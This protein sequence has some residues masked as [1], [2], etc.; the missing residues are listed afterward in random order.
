MFFGNKNKILKVVIW[1]IVIAF[2]GGG[3]GIGGSSLIMACKEKGQQDALHREALEKDE[4][5]LRIPD[6]IRN[7]E[8][9][10]IGEDKI[11]AGKFFDYFRKLNPEIK[12]RYTTVE[13]R[14]QVLDYIIEREIINNFAISSKVEVSEEDRIKVLYRLMGDQLKN[15][16]QTQVKDMI[17]KGYFDAAELNYAVTENKV[18]KMV[19]V[20]PEDRS[21]ENLRKYYEQHK[22]RYMKDNEYLV[23]HIMIKKDTPEL[24]KAVKNNIKEGTLERYYENNKRKYTGQAAVRLKG[25]FINPENFQVNSVEE[26]EIKEYF[27]KNS[28]KYIVE[29]EVKASHIL[30]KNEQKAKEILD[31]VKKGESFEELAEEY[32]EDPGSAKLKG[33]LGWFKRNT[34]VKEFDSKVFSMKPGEVSNLVATNFGYHIIKLYEKKDRREKTLEEVRNEIVNEI[35]KDLK[36]EKAQEVIDEIAY[37]INSGE[38]FE[39]YIDK[40]HGATA[41]FEG[42]LDWVTK[43]EQTSNLH[44]DRLEGE[45]FR[46]KRL[47]PEVENVIFNLRLG[48]V[49]EVVKSSTGFHLFRLVDRRQ[50]E[51][52]PYAEVKNQVEKDFMVWQKNILANNKAREALNKINS[53]HEFAAV[54]K[55]YSDGNTSEKGG[56]LPWFPMGVLPEERKDLQ[57]ALDG[58]IASFT[59]FF[60][61]NQFQAGVSVANEIENAVKRLQKGE[62]SQVVETSDAYHI[63]K[64]EDIRDGE[65]PTFEEIYAQLVEDVSVEITEEDLLDYYN[66]NIERYTEPEQVKVAHILVSEIAKAAMVYDMV[67][68]DGDFSKIAKENSEDYTKD[69]GGEIGYI[70]RGNMP[71]KFEE[72]AFSLEINEVSEPV[73]TTY[74]FHII[75]VLDKKPSVVATFEDKKEEIRDELFSPH[76]DRL[77]QQWLTEQKNKFGIVKNYKEF[78]VLIKY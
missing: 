40:S 20:L 35:K 57:E 47:L 63:I 7:I 55:E 28:Q 46:R 65:I 2:A 42:D 22:F 18:K 1:V 69:N 58:Q 44:I 74:G 26:N 13:Q 36:W 49:S 34:M 77:F 53:G 15:V 62:I 25:I 72:V 66:S 59:Y 78:D 60:K 32:S 48:Q 67:K 6:D 14:E 12:N 50:A 61:N 16:P 10:K 43:G 45:I 70:S 29:E 51:I 31:R 27:E 24:E 19:T 23:S 64:L 76:Q 17:E 3:I 68:A 56:E 5:R 30:I 33:D 71:E 21:D 75:K 39:S 37:K 9:A 4:E 11:T 41:S 38:T 8:L 54:A 73:E 52:R